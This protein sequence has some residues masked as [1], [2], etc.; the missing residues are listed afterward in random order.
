MLLQGGDM[1][2]VAMLF[3]SMFLP[4]GARYSVDATL[5]SNRASSA[6]V[7]LSATNTYFA[8]ATAQ[9]CCRPWRYISFFRVVKDR[10]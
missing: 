7:P 10:G 2:L 9:F 4:L 8:V 5:V 6:V 1:L 3:W